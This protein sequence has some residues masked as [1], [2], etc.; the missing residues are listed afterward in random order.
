MPRGDTLAEST[1]RRPVSSENRPRRRKPDCVDRSH[2]V[3][4]ARGDQRV[5]R[6]ARRRQRQVRNEAP[7]QDDRHARAVDGER[8]LPAPDRSENEV[9]VTRL[10]GRASRRVDDADGELAIDQRNCGKARR[11][12]WGRDGRTRGRARTC[13]QANRNDD[14][15]DDGPAGRANTRRERT[16][17][18]HGLKLISDTAWSGG[19]RARGERPLDRD[20]PRI[21][22]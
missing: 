20:I 15:R 19:H 17:L 18:Y 5:L 14:S 13:R 6:S 2:R 1:T 11:N 3:G 22:L 16:V 10:D 9:G 7:V 8:R 4:T 12:K 21:S